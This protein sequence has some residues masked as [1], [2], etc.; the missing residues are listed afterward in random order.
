MRGARPSRFERVEVDGAPSPAR[1]ALAVRPVHGEHRQR[2]RHRTRQPPGGRIEVDEPVLRARSGQQLVPR[3]LQVRPGLA[4][5]PE[6][7]GQAP[8]DVAGAGL[9]R[10]RG[11]LSAQ[12]RRLIELPGGEVVVHCVESG[13]EAGAGVGGDRDRQLGDERGRLGVAAAPLL[14]SRGRG[15]GPQDRVGAGGG[16]EPVAQRRE[17]GQRGRGPLVQL[18]LAGLGQVADEGRPDQRVG[19]RDPDLAALT[20]VE[21]PEQPSGHRVVHGGEHVDDPGDLPQ[22]GGGGR[23]LEDGGGHDDRLDHRAGPGQPAQDQG[24]EGPRGREGAVG[25]EGVGRELLEQRA[26][27]EGDS[28]GVGSQ[29]LGGRPAHRVAHVLGGHPTDIL[30]AERPDRESGAL[31][32]DQPDEHLG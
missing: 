16:G 15:V 21:D 23:V 25:G 28:A 18:H 4:A 31:V 22:R 19:D 14:G 24:V 2:R 6:H 3:R 5:R 29:A 8:G 26:E 27:V 13:E 7:V 9:G 1:A 12:P 10:G 20:G 17:T 32:V 11:E 30:P